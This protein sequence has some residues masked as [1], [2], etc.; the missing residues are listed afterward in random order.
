[1]CLER[2]PYDA[3]YILSRVNSHHEKVSS[4]WIQPKFRANEITKLNKAVRDQ[5]PVITFSS[6]QR[7]STLDASSADHSGGDSDVI[8]KLITINVTYRI[9][10]GS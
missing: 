7:A 5:P 9:R 8:K 2:E 3:V 1:M 10:V 4:G 6:R